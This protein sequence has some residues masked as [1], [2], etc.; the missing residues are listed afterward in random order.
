MRQVH[1]TGIRLFIAAQALYEGWWKFDAKKNRQV[2]LAE[3]GHPQSPYRQSPRVQ[4]PK[5]GHQKLPI[6]DKKDIPAG[7]LEQGRN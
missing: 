5:A 2:G 6:P 4:V 3:R 7:E 1:P